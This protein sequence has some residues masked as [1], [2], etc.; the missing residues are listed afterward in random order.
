MAKKKYPR[1]PNAPKKPT[2]PFLY[3]MMDVAKSVKEE[4][5]L[6]SGDGLNIRSRVSKEC[7]RRWSIMTTE[8]KEKYNEMFKEDSKRYQEAVKNYKPSLEFV[9]RARLA[10][11]HN[12]SVINPERNISSVPHMV[13]SYFDYLA[14]SWSKVA[15]S[16]P[17]L[18]PDQVQ[19][20]VWRRWSEGEPGGSS[21]DV[22]Q[23][24]VKKPTKKR[25]RKKVVKDPASVNE[26]KAPRQAFQIF[27]TTMKEELEKQLPD[28]SYADMLKHVSAKWK[29]MT[30]EQKVPFFEFERTE[31][32]K[33]EVQMKE[34]IN[35]NVAIIVGVEKEMDIELKPNLEVENKSNVG[36]D[37]KLDDMK[38]DEEQERPDVIADDNLKDDSDLKERKLEIDLS[39][40]SDNEG[41]DQDMRS[42]ETRLSFSSSDDDTSDSEKES[43]EKGD[44]DSVD[45]IDV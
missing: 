43:D 22:N 2:R 18:E 30:Y 5:G 39:D 24:V 9:E 26:P 6:T 28:M 16:L 36:D 4:L 13:R 33:Y 32:E 12:T 40:T 1:D 7:G 23:N 29:V 37:I 3:F 25:L 8:E 21:M 38:V 34:K 14:S 42:S 20:E 11:L 27:L 19:E 45:M 15:A 17:K 41:D 10:K 31:K 44:D 35:K